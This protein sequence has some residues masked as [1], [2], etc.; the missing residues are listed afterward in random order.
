MN[1]QI[2]KSPGNPNWQPGRS[3][4]P[5]GRPLGARQRIAEKMLAD[6]AD[7]WQRRGAEVLERLAD[8]EPSKLAALGFGLLPKDI[9]MKVEWQPPR[10][11]TQDDHRQLVG[12]LDAIEAAG[13]GDVPPAEL[14]AGIETYLRSEM[15]RPIENAPALA[16]SQA[17]AILEAEPEPVA[18]PKPPF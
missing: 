12:L 16:A 13:L 14:F 4:N 2:I 11:L 5:S 15:A 6:L 8:E 9:F 10:G 3:G 17:I 1:K 7:V 18:V